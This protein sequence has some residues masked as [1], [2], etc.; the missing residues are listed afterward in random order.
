MDRRT[1]IKWVLAA[2]AAWPLIEAP[3]AAAARRAANQ[4]H[5]RI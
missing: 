4:R 2:G 5:F 3:T 1:T